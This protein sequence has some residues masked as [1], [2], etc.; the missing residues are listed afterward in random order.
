MQHTSRGT[1]TRSGDLILLSCNMR[2]THSAHWTLATLGRVRGANH[3]S[4]FHQSFV[5]QRRITRLINIITRAIPKPR[6]ARARI[7]INISSV[8]SH[9][10]SRDISIDDR[11]PLPEGDRSDGA[12]AIRS[13]PRQFFQRQTVA[14]NF[15][16]IF[17]NNHLGSRL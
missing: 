10:H 4:Q 2:A 13:N 5:S 6:F 12:G 14:R 3:C 8:N 11:F 1:P 15:P 7:A 9:H 17:P 16:V